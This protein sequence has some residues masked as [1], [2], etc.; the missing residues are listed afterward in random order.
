M[1]GGSMRRT[2][3]A[4]VAGMATAAAAHAGTER[5][6]AQALTLD[7]APSQLPRLGTIDQRFQSYNVE[8][9]EVTGG[10][11]WKPYAA[12]PPSHDTPSARSTPAGRNRDLFEY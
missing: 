12:A 1:P 2:V 4:L 6:A 11:F 10:E 3:A 9:V 8:M 5:A 7:V